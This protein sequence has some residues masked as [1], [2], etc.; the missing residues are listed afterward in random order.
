MKLHKKLITVFLSLIITYSINAQEGSLSG[1]LID[2][3]EETIPF[4]TVAMVK[5]P[6]STVVTGTTTDLDGAFELGTPEE[7]KYLLRF[8]AIGFTS[9]FTDAFNISSPNYSRDFGQVII[10]EEMTMLNEVMVQ[11]WR[12]R[13]ELEAGKMVVRVEGTAMAA[14]SSAFE[15]VSKSPGISADQ[16]GN[17]RLNGKTGVKIMIN[18]RLTYLSA[19]QLK[20]MLESMPAENIKNIE[21]I[22]NPSAKYDAEGSAGIINIILKE[23]LGAGFNGSVYGGVEFNE[24]NWYNAGANLNYNSGKWNTYFSADLSKRGFMREQEIW[25]EYTYDFEYDYYH[26][27]GVQLETKWIPSFQAGVDYQLNE[28]HSIGFSGNYSFYEENG[29]WN[30]ETEL[31]QDGIGDLETISAKN[32]MIEDYGN[33]RF[34]VHYDAKLDTVG[35]NLSVNLDYVQLS[36]DLDSYFTNNYFFPVDEETDVEKLFNRSVSDYEIF[37][38]QADLSLPLN[39]RSEFSIGVKGSK[40]IS[41]S[42]L[43]FYLGE[44]TGGELDRTRSN[45][46]TYEEEIYAAYASYS[47]RLSDTWDLQLGLRAEKTVGKGIS[48]TMNRINEKS[49]LDLFPNF[50][51]SQKV[52][53]NYQLN[54]SYSKRINRPSY[55]RLNPFLFYLDPYTYIVG[56]PDLEAEITSSYGVNQTLFGKYMLM[57]NYS[58]TKGATAEYPRTDMETGQAILTT[59]NTDHKDSYSATLVVPV[60]ITSFWNAENTAVV[61][62]TNF[63]IPYEE[64]VVEND[65]LYYSL[66]S[67]HRI[68][69]PWDLNLELNANY[70]GPMA[71]GV[72]TIGERWYLDAGL[73]KSFL[74][75]R[76]DLTV[77]ATDIF[78]GQQINVESEYPGSTF[79]LE[80]HF[81]TQGVSFNLRYRFN[82]SDAPK[83]SR[84]NQLEELNRAGG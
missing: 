24:E 27:T 64:G 29:I 6:D 84:Q 25:R 63:D 80:Q 28:N 36:K 67:N 48:P 60:E 73:K 76:L 34:N 19:D 30:T 70:S 56:N 26:Q 39:S 14:G 44:D 62:Q 38:A 45:S 74:N 55:S 59:A 5:L 9:T 46:F 8:S 12:P 72:A 17:L 65:V 61:N 71:Y 50:Q 49:Y 33:G 18:G 31:G 51:L 7:G 77:K 2:P 75:E 40:V 4:A 79:R 37:A 83:K 22:H 3:K 66:Q 52:S 43:Q 23:N 35:T 20:T 42:D 82:G 16:D 47:N 54:Y 1:S 13:V 32:R 57:L 78:A 10:K 41:E 15:I 21:L 53:E 58:R 81:F 69:L 11:A 68:S